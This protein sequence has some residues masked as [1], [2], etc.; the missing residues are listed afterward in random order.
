MVYISHINSL[1]KLLIAKK[2]VVMGGC[3]R[4]KYLLQDGEIKREC[5]RVNPWPPRGFYT[6][7]SVAEAYFQRGQEFCHLVV[8][9]I[10]VKYFIKVH[11]KI[12]FVIWVL[13]F[14]IKGTSFL[15]THAS[16]I[17]H[18]ALFQW[19]TGKISISFHTNSGFE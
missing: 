10:L 12:V 8:T 18:T 3:R 1:N 6:D 16:L 15:T 13:L 5:Y 4:G 9:E 7:P 19:V 2:K 14:R 11:V 17:H